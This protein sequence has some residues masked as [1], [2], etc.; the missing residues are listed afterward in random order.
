MKKIYEKPILDIT[1][2]NVENV[3]ALSGTFQNNTIYSP[4]DTT[5][6]WEDFFN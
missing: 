3:I 2:C 1:I 5:V 4:N 6:A